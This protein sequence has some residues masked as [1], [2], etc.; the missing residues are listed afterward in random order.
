MSA[1]AGIIAF[2]KTL[3]SD[4][5]FFDLKNS[6]LKRGHGFEFNRANNYLFCNVKNNESRSNKYIIETNE[7][8][9]NFDGR[10]ENKEEIQEKF[11]L[12]NGLNDSEICIS[13]FEKLGKDSFNYIVGA[14][15]IVIFDKVQKKIICSRDQL[16][17]RPLFYSYDDEAF[18]YASE[19]KFI[20]KFKEINKNINEIKL[21]NFLIGGDINPSMTYF[22]NIQKI[23]RGCILEI[24]S[25]YINNTKYFEF[26]RN[27]DRFEK[28]ANFVEIFLEKFSNVINSQ[29]PN[30]DKVGSALSGGLDSSSVTRMLISNNKKFKLNKE[31]YSF[32]YR[33]TD[34]EQKDRIGTDEMNYVN[35]VINMGDINPIIINIKSKNIIKD[36]LDSQSKFS[37]P[38]LH[39]NRY[40]ELEMIK[41]CKENQIQTLFTGYDGDCTISYGMEN[42]Q[43]LLSKNKFFRA[44]SLNNKVRNKLDLKNNTVRMLLMYVFIKRLPFIFHFLIKKFK[45]FEKFTE[46]QKFLSTSLKKDIDY[47]EAL[48]DIREKMFNYEESHQRLLNSHSFSN[49]FEALDIDYSYNEIEERHPFCNHEFM[50]LCLDLPIETKLNKG[51]TRYI[52]R[53][54][55]KGIIPSSIYHRMKKS[56]LSP[57]FLYSFDSMKDDLFENLIYSRTEINSL[58]NIENIKKMAKQNNLSNNEKSYIVSYNCVNEWLRANK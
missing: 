31:I 33:F 5:S 44:I 12:K 41:A 52:L 3:I 42:I 49:N 27:P 45:G 38:C 22:E 18:I 51:L 50:Q 21:R 29:I 10:I 43:A 2:K 40:L 17:I 53:E 26:K 34:L 36:L 54:S 30:E 20:F 19:I 7:Y 23:P 46:N 25:N 13:L 24:S 28:D 32:S 37:E 58:L 14:F 8:I 11:K 55:M 4:S 35:D 57:Y 1:I 48:K 15:V 6:L 16:G 56:N 9:F 39:G 47:A